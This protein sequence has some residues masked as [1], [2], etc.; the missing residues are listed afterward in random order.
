MGWGHR[1]L[2]TH[3]CILDKTN[4]IERVTSI[5]VGIKGVA[6]AHMR[7]QSSYPPLLWLPQAYNC[8]SAQLG[9]GHRLLQTHRSILDKCN[10]IEC[11]VPIPT[12]I[13]GLATAHI[14]L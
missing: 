5:P 1:P 2:Q 10:D 11:V 4:A 13:Q 9:W 14:R 6:T 8:G 3:R 7:L 12:G